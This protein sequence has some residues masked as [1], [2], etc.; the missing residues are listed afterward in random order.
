MEQWLKNKLDRYS[1]GEIKKLTPYQLMQEVFHLRTISFANCRLKFSPV[2]GLNH[3]QCKSYSLN[4]SCNKLTSLH[5]LCFV[6]QFGKLDISSNKLKMHQLVFLTDKIKYLKCGDNYF[7]ENDAIQLL[8]LCFPATKVKMQNTLPFN[9]SSNWK[10]LLSDQFI[11]E[12]LFQVN[13]ELCSILNLSFQRVSQLCAENAIC[14][15]NVQKFRD[16]CES[17]ADFQACIRGIA[18]F[19]VKTQF[20]GLEN[21]LELKNANVGLLELSS[22]Q[23][24]DKKTEFAA[25]NAEMKALVNETRLKMINVEL[26]AGG[27]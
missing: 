15:Q 25:I 23:L 27:E 9:E 8:R 14:A 26:E 16:Q 1:Y 21:D 10:T 11:R 4:L 17:Y 24:K 7:A 3:E 18:L 5:S 22:I 2:V 6:P 20:P 13:C 19:L 12:L